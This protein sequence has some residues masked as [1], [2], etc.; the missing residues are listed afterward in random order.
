MQ[1][2]DHAAL[3]QRI[4][5]LGLEHVGVADGDHA[6]V[7]HGARVVFRHVD[8]VE[9]GV[10]IRH[11]PG[12]G[13]EREALL[14][15]VEQIIDVLGEGLGQ[16]LAAVLGHRHGTAILVK[17]FG[18]PFGV[19]A[20]ADGGQ[21]GAHHRGRLE[22]PEAG[23]FVRLIAKCAVQGFARIVL[24][25]GDRHVGGDDPAGGSEHLEIEGGL[26]VRLVEHG[27]DA[28]GIRHLELGVQVDVA[29]GRVDRTVQA[30]AGVGV[31]AQ[32]LD[33]DLV[34][35][36]QIRKLNA[37][38]LERRSRV[39]RLAIELDGGDLIGNQVKECR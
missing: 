4:G 11:A 14:G 19:R 10:R 26:Q 31:A 35:F 24:D 36:L 6:D 21:V 25:G 2:G 1:H 16:G 8:L 30:F 32:R 20:G 34:L 7:L 33:G 9:L 12:L 5:H 27:V 17:V 28:A 39:Q 37:V 38:V 22:V 18:V 29:I 13:V 15:D 23:A 3:G